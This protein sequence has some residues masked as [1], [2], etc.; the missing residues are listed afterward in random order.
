MLLSFFKK[1]LLLIPLLIV[2]N[3][4]LAIF[5]YKS[6]LSIRAPSVEPLSL[7][8]AVAVF[9]LAFAV[10]VGGIVSLV[11]VFSRRGEDKAWTGGEREVERLA[12]DLALVESARAEAEL[13]S[14]A[15]SDFLAVISHEL[16]T[17]LNAILG[18]A[19]IIEDRTY[20]PAEEERYTDAARNIREGGEHMLGIVNNI[21]DLSKVEAGGM[22]LNEETFDLLEMV[23]AAVTLI[24]GRAGTLGITLKVSLPDRL[25]PL[26][27]DGRL[28]KQM[29]IN[30]LS[31]AVENT[32]ADGWVVITAERD[33]KGGLTIAIADTGRGIAEDDL[34]L[35]LTPFRTFGDQQA[36]MPHGIGLGLPLVKSL[37]ELHGGAFQ[38]NSKLGTGTTV[39]LT[40]PPARVGARVGDRVGLGGEARLNGTS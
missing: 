23:H 4:I 14:R 34:A 13:A 7:I 21:L 33:G 40:F 10:M 12:R 6:L 25:P 32:P 16:R 38:I 20:G 17:P 9:V 18:F 37:I 31:N 19:A 8:S 5:N 2:R 27:A 29:L 28:V 11:R 3:I 36:R 22:A 26:F 39:A 35:A 15:K 1:F 24:Q 30:L